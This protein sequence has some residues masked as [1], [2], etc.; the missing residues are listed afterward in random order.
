[1]NRCKSRG[2][3]TLKDLSNKVLQM[4]E[5]FSNKY[6]IDIGL[7]YACMKLQEELGELV[8]EHLNTQGM[9]RKTPDREALCDEFADVQ[10]SLLLLAHLHGVDIEEACIGKWDRQ[11]KDSLTKL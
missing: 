5:N 4:S 7:N 10:Y 2:D 8:A 11:V 6:N 3:N 9:T 1:M